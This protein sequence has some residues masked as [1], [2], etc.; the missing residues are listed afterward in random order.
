MS[1]DDERSAVNSC[2]NTSRVL[3]KPVL[4]KYSW[5]AEIKISD[6][7]FIYGLSAVWFYEFYL[8]D[9]INID[10]WYWDCELCFS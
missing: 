8:E 2:W 6:E 7:D 9:C 4:R 10:G 1:W 3:K 5:I